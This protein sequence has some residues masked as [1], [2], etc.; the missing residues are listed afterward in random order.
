MADIQRLE[1]AIDFSRKFPGVETT[2][3]GMIIADEAVGMDEAHEIADHLKS[4]YGMTE[5]AKQS[6]SMNLADLVNYL[7]GRFGDLAWQ[8]I[9]K[10]H[11]QK[12]KP[13]CWAMKLIPLEKRR[14]SP[15]LTPS[16]YKAVATVAACDLPFVREDDVEWFQMC[17]DENQWTIRRMNEEINTEMTRRIIELQPEDMREQWQAWLDEMRE[18]KAEPKFKDFWDIVQAGWLE[19]EKIRFDARRV[20][21]VAKLKERKRQIGKR[22]YSMK[23]D[24]CW[25]DGMECGKR[26]GNE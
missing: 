20:D 14:L 2:K 21:P 19:A 15:S 23:R 6:V 16:H 8:I 18:H 11:Y 10:S 26:M 22:W 4:F 1:R 25:L 17:A 13:L 3:S 9:D 7:K 12:F 5:V 24:S